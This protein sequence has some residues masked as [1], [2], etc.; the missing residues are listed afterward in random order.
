MV[1]LG[2]LGAGG[3][4]SSSNSASLDGAVVVGTGSEGQ[5]SEAFR[6]TGATEMV[7]LGKI[8]QYCEALGYCFFDSSAVATSLD[9]SVIVGM[10]STSTHGARRP[11]MHRRSAAGHV[12]E[13]AS[14]QIAGTESAGRFGRQIPRSLPR[15]GGADA[16]GRAWEVA[17][18]LLRDRGNVRGVMPRF[19]GMSNSDCII[20]ML[21]SQD[22]DSGGNRLSTALRRRNGI[23]GMRCGPD[24]RRAR[25]PA[26]VRQSI[27][28]T[29]QA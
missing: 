18:P 29:S 17:R 22:R 16:H 8:G 12:P 4:G 24:H 1:G 23:S 5:F 21:R 3:F 2:D 9:G 19:G 7:G 10:T 11:G 27:R 28:R 15:A 13:D 20:P 25:G 6:W 26:G 14:P